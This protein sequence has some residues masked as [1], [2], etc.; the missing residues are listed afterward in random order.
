MLLIIVYI[1]ILTLFIKRKR[2]PMSKTF[3]PQDAESAILYAREKYGKQFAT[4]FEKVMRLETSTA[5]GAF[6]SLQYK[7]T[8]TPGM[9]S[10]AWI[11][12]P[13]NIA[14][15]QMKDN[16]TGKLRRFVVFPDTK[17]FADYFYKYVERN[18]GNYLTWN[19]RDPEIQ[20]RYA[21]KLNLIK[22]KIA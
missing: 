18:N 20:K 17:T 7:L 12:L 10:G 6:T 5:N 4:I 16:Q 22:A 11:G 2:K 14:T 1:L 3:D 9:E 21:E 13:K 19:S 8:G 15:V